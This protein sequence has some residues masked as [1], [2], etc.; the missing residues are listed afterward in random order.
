V[1]AM[2]DHDRRADRLTTRLA[3]LRELTQDG[4]GRLPAD[5]VERAERTV[6]QAETR[7]GHGS[8]HTVV[9]IAGATGSGKSS[10]F[11]A[12][13]GDV[14][15]EVGVRRPTTST[16]QAAVF[17]GGAD[18]LLDWLDVPRRHVV[19]GTELDGLVLLDLPDHDSVEQAHRDEVD[20]LV[21]V[22]DAFLWVLDPQKYA[23]AA[24]HHD[25]LSR[26]A[27]HRAVTLVILNQIDAVAADTDR[28]AMVDHV[29]RLLVADGLTGVRTMTTSTRT[30]EGVD[31]LR[32]ELAARV[33]E[34]QALVARLDADVDWL[35]DDLRV[36]VGDATPG[37]LG[38]DDEQRLADALAFAGGVDAIA[39]AVG[40]AHRHRSVKHAG[41]PPVRWAKGLR[42][43]PLRRLGLDRG[44]GSAVV[45]RPDGPTVARTSRPAP[46]AVG[47]AAVDEALRGVAAEAARDLPDLWVDRVHEV[48]V[49]RRDDVADALDVA[50]ASA[51]LPTAPPRWWTVAASVQWVLAVVMVVGLVWSVA[52][53][54]VAWL[55]L[56]DLPTPELREIP[57]PTLLLLGAATLGLLLAGVARWAAAAGGRR[58]A[59]VTR[60]DLRRRTA[61][62]GRDLVVGPVN[63]ELEQ[64]SRLQARVHRL[65]H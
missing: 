26:F 3:V 4:P 32:R 50:V 36:A 63:A 45:P 1:S 34:R 58:R 22:V 17:G 53:G 48:A 27:A 23:D 38:R 20:R 29:G 31:A 30:G 24:L 21:L 40:A 57:L 7:L 49:A 55:G 11:N 65:D 9:A 8:A 51:E 44:D 61:E 10:L 18:E 41:W 13:V 33:A 14:V 15:A 25:Y 39:D 52:L 16:A 19:S 5:V 12:L 60:R 2:R 64:L 47:E 28:R 43:D 46:S 59:E 35:V 6:G 42:P 37:I 62:V 54:V 56:P